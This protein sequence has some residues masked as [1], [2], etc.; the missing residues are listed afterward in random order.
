MNEPIELVEPQ[1]MTEAQ[2]AGLARLY[3]DEDIRSYLNHAIAMANAN[4]L[5][6]LKAGNPA[7]ATEFAVRLD[8]LKQLLDKGK[9]MFSQAEKLQ[10][11]PLQE[12]IKEDAPN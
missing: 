9:L 7:S 10:R 5:S 11:K 4:V 2:K 3:A 1:R 12:L 6:S 8:A